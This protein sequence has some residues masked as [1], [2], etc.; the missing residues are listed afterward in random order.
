M[1]KD[2]PLDDRKYNE[3]NEDSQMGQNIPKK[4][5]KK[6]L[7]DLGKPSWPIA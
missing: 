6:L 4:C 7:F 5:L 2:G 1:E 3:N